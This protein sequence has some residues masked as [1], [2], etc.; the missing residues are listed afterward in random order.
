LDKQ[1]LVDKYCV[2]STVY[3]SC[4]KNKLFDKRSKTVIEHKRR[5][6]KEKDKVCLKFEL[7]LHSTN[8]VINYSLLVIKVKIKI[9]CL[10]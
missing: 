9:P 3:S 10:L 1:Y 6:T 8:S 2:S 4:S 7:Q 5:D